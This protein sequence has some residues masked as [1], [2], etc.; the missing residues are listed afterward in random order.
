MVD[1]IRPGRSLDFIEREVR[2]TQHADNWSGLV[3]QAVNGLAF[4][5]GTVDPNNNVEA[6]LGKEYFN[7]NTEEFWKKTTASGTTGWKQIT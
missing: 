7:S 5:T 6:A 2:L 4:L 1:I 3:T